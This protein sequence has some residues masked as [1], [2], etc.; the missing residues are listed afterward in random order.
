MDCKGVT[1]L[2]RGNGLFSY[3]AA[4]VVVAVG[5]VLVS[6]RESQISYYSVK[7]SIFHSLFYHPLIPPCEGGESGD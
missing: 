5:I 2:D 1:A 4:D 3:Y 6:A 7:T